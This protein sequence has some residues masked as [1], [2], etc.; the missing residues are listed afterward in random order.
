LS[1]L[2]QLTAKPESVVL[3]HAKG[4]ISFGFH[5][6]DVHLVMGPMDGSTPVAFRVLIDGEPLRDASRSDV[7]DGGAGLLT[8]SRMYQLVRQRGPIADRFSTIESSIAVRRRSH[9]RSADE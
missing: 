9:S 7:D 1:A 8:E 5:A 6:R 4:G 3:H 2:G